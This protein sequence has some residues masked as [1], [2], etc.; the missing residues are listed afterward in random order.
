[1]AIYEE[2]KHRWLRWFTLD[3]KAGP[4]WPSGL[5]KADWDKKKAVLA[6][7]K[8]TGITEVLQAAQKAFDKALAERKSLPEKSV[9]EETEK[10]AK[11][12]WNGKTMNALRD[13]VTAVTKKAAAIDEA[14]VGSLAPEASIKKTKAAAEQIE[15]AATALSK[16]LAKDKFRDVWEQYVN[17]LEE[18]IQVKR[19]TKAAVDLEELKSQLCIVTEFIH[20]EGITGALRITE[21]DLPEEAGEKKKAEEQR[22]L[23][24]KAVHRGVIVKRSELN[25]ELQKVR[26]HVKSGDVV[27]DAGGKPA[28]KTKDFEGKAQLWSGRSSPGLTPKLTPGSVA[29]ELRDFKTQLE[30]ITPL[31]NLATAK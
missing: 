31:V 23:A 24:C 6:K 4:V 18:T 22:A 20:G 13:A 17:G 7:G 28:E 30:E 27:I 14:Y 26:A 16:V 12:Y 1:M 19:S 15:K 10:E 29:K 3:K 11:E 21:R 5:T 2:S 25:I 9:T 8:K